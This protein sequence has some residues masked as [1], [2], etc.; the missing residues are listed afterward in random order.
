MERQQPLGT[1]IATFEAVYDLGT[2]SEQVL[3]N[4]LVPFGSIGSD[5]QTTHLWRRVWTTSLP[6]KEQSVDSFGASH[7]AWVLLQ[8]N[9]HFLVWGK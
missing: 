5:L 1:E 8:V 2:R 7:I 4:W 3:I 6:P 9:T